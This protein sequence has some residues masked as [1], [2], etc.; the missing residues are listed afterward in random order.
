MLTETINGF[1]LSP[2]QKRLWLLQQENS[3]YVA[4][5]AIL[6][7]GDLNKEALKAALHQVVCRHEILRT[8][9]RKISGIK[10]PI[11]VVEDSCIFS[12]QEISLSNCDTEAVAIELTCQDEIRKPFNLEQ[13]PLLRA[14]LLKLSGNKH[15]LVIT[16]PALCADSETLKNL[17]WGISEFYGDG[18]DKEVVQYAHLAKSIINRTRSRNI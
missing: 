18:S 15:I 10:M 4:Q 6:L 7:E 11:M 2:Q 13:A 1:R 9:F 5:T 8:S 17:F 3:T 16:L 12:W 14:S